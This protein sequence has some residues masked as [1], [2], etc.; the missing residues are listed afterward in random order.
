[1]Q[2]WFHN[3]HEERQAK[4]TSSPDAFKLFVDLS[5]FFVPK[6][7]ESSQKPKG[8][9]FVV[10]MVEIVNHDCIYV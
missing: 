4:S 7:P 8:H 2:K 9:P 6:E 3:K 10:S 1:M 5:G